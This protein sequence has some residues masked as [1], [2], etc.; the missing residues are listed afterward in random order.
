MRLM[1]GHSINW[2]EPYGV[3]E[4]VEGY[5]LDKP[6]A[7][8]SLLDDV[9]DLITIA[10]QRGGPAK[11]ILALEPEQGSAVIGVIYQVQKYDTDKQ[12]ARASLLD[13][14]KRLI[15]KANVVSETS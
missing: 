11:M 8:A 4:N 14:I 9:A 10:K 5:N 3:I 1:V 12:M 7:S 15:K 13:D 6:L 2:E